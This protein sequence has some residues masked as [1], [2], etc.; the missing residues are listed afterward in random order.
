MIWEKPADFK[1]AL[2]AFVAAANALP[3]AAAKGGDAYGQAF[4]ALGKSC[5]GCHENFR[6]KKE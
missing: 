2:D 6:Q 3:A 1:V 4:G 5:K